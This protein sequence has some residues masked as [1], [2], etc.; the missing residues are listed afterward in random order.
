MKEI[1]AKIAIAAVN[2]NPNIVHRIAKN[3]DMLSRP[4]I[5]EDVT[6]SNLYCDEYDEIGKAYVIDSKEYC[7]MIRM[8]LVYIDVPDYHPEYVIRRSINHAFRSSC[9][10]HDCCG[11]RFENVIAAIECGH[12]FWLVRTHFGI[13]I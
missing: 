4:E 2:H 5:L 9:G 1:L 7:G 12:G 6:S 11:C 10:H 3:V 8:R 13:N